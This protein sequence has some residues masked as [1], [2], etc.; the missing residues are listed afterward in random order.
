MAAPTRSVEMRLRLLFGI[1]TPQVEHDH[2]ADEGNGVQ[3]E[4]GARSDG[5][6]HCASQRRTDGARQIEAHGVESDGGGQFGT[7]APDRA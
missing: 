7:A 4:R 6:H 2:H 5:R 3:D 1:A